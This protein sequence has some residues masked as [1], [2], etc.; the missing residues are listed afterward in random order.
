MQ[1]SGIG[2]AAVGGV[3]MPA[4]A[5]TEPPHSAGYRI[6]DETAR[7]ALH[8]E[9]P[10]AASEH[11]RRHHLVVDPAL[12]RGRPCLARARSHS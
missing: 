8:L 2:E 7:E 6:A 11:R 3:L 1:R 4:S 5:P 12:V 10:S 9:V